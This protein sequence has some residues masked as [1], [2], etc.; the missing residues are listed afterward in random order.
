LNLNLFSWREIL[1]E[2]LRRN[3]EL[4]KA[5]EVP[6]LRRPKKLKITTNLR[7]EKEEKEIEWT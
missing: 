3:V 5:L 4:F 2:G 1:T 6:E 7:R